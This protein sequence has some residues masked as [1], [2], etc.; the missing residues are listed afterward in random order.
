MTEA[1]FLAPREKVELGA[2]IVP[3][4]L[5]RPRLRLIIG[6]WRRMRLRMVFMRMRLSTR[7]SVVIILIVVVWRRWAIDDRPVVIGRRR[8]NNIHFR[9]RE[10]AT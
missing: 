1:L 9:G 5:C 10:Q 3:A 8:R 2:D 7:R 6:S 4:R